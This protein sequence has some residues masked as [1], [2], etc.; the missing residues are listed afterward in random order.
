MR[1]RSRLLSLSWLWAFVLITV[2]WLK[3]RG[4][5]NWVVC[6]TSVPIIP[7]AVEFDFRWRWFV[8]ISSFSWYHISADES[9]RCRFPSYL[10]CCVVRFEKTQDVWFT[11]AASS[12]QQNLT[13]ILVPLEEKGPG[14]GEKSKKLWKIHLMPLAGTWRKQ[15]AA[16]LVEGH[17]PSHYAVFLFTSVH[18]THSPAFPKWSPQLRKVSLLDLLG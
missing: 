3:D 6:W 9:S 1:T 14:M 10:F 12:F 15:R 17:L 16:D 7:T 11:L 5:L 8:F 2:V 4:W 13:C 18:V